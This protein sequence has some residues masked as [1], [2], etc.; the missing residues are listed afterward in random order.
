M[1]HRNMINR[2]GATKRSG[3]DEILCLQSFLRVK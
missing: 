3:N 1:W 2:D